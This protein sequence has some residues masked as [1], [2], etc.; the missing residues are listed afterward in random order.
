MRKKL[1]YVAMAY[2]IFRSSFVGIS[3][4]ALITRV[5]QSA[6]ISMII[7]FILGFIPIILF[8]SIANYKDNLALPDKLDSLFPKAKTI[9]KI[10]LFISV[11]LITILNFWN[12][13]NLVVSQFLSKTPI[14]VIAITFIIPIVFLISKENKIISRVILILFGISS[15]LFLASATGLINKFEINNLLPLTEYNPL[16]GVLSYISYNILPIF[17]ILIFPGKE[18]KE[19]LFYG[20]IGSFISL[21]IVMLFIIA[22][23]GID[24]VTIFQYPEFH[25]LKLAF[26]EA[27]TFRLENVLAIQWILDIFV[28]STIGLKFCNDI[29]NIKKGYIIPILLIILNNYLFSSN[30]IANAL[31]T[32]VFPYLIPVPFLGIP[33]IIWIK[34][35]IKKEQYVP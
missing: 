16:R 30:T 12:L 2:F 4:V 13:T 15:I 33:I 8:Y 18:I 1:G 11:F 9:I 3:S 7:A 19:S 6:W 14:M 10:V 28:F 27:V 23:L 32:Y 25:I 34:M 21:M 22:V 26:E 20:Y 24:L 35:K 29:L 17:I 31:I 5:H